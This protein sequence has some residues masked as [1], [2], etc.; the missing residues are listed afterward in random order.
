MKVYV[1]DTEYLSWKNNELNFNTLKLKLKN[2]PE[3]IQI[4]IKE[5]FSPK[6]NEIL[7]FIKPKYYQKYPKRISKITSIKKSFLDKNGLDFIDA[8]KILIK[9]ISKNSIMI[10]NGNDSGI[11]NY[12]IKLNKI[13]KIGNKVNF[14]DFNDLLRSLYPELF[15]KNNFVSISSIKKIFNLRESKNHNA[16]NDVNSLI[17]FLKKKK[18]RKSFF[19]K[20]NKLFYKFHL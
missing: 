6:K 10:S 5:I 20:N 11:I 18:I 1:I 7:L 12:N 8:Y 19:F 17:E 14:F 13:K 15:K 3:I 16:K 2:P 9:F 4:Y